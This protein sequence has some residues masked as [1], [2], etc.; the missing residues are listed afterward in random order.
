MLLLQVVK[1][2][3]LERLCPEHR[4]RKK[5]FL[6]RFYPSRNRVE[7]NGT[8]S[9]IS[10]SSSIAVRRA[11]GDTCAAAAASSIL[12]FSSFGAIFAPAIHPCDTLLTS[13]Y[14]SIQFG[15][16]RKLIKFNINI[17]FS[18]YKA[19]VTSFVIIIFLKESFVFRKGLIS[20]CLFSSSGREYAD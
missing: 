2:F 14:I 8:S 7:R 6:F 20:C 1:N 11:S 10:Y 5:L 3:S 9:H 15:S 13:I 4:N 17:P 19:G 12:S 18:S 16:V